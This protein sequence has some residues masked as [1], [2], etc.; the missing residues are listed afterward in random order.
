[1]HVPHLLEL[2]KL[3]DLLEDVVG[4]HEEHSTPHTVQHQTLGVSDKSMIVASW[5]MELVATS[6]LNVDVVGYQELRRKT[7]QAVELHFLM[8]KLVV[9]TCQRIVAPAASSCSGP[10]LLEKVGG[11]IDRIA[12][13]DF[14][15]L[16]DCYTRSNVGERTRT[17]RLS[18]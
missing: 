17:N 18:G 3:V 4:F 14:A 15:N 12:G 9:G 11:Y 8:S 10:R 6:S 5:K 1:M 13:A 16:R 2:L 7:F